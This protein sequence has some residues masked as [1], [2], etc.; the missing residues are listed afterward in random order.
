MLETISKNL[1]LLLTLIIPGFCTYGFWRLLLLFEPSTSLNIEAINKIDDSTI[2]SSSIIIGIALS[3][4]A[5]AI[6][7]E[8]ILALVSKLKKKSWPNL[9]SLF[10]E[11]FEL[12][13]AGK[14]NESATRIIGNYFLSV[15]MSIGIIFLLFYF[16]AYKCLSICHWIPIALIILFSATLITIVYRML[17]AK[18]VIE[19]CKKS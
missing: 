7:I 17:N 9:Y 19:E 16:V 12:T 8:A 15:N 11:R 13:A 10:C 18:W 14:L 1:W 4:Q 3:Q 2:L 5:F 6:A